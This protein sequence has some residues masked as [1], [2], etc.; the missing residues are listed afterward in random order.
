VHFKIRG[1]YAHTDADVER[2]GERDCRYATFLQSR[3]NHVPRAL[4]Q[5]FRGGFFHDGTVGAINVLR[6]WRRIE[7]LVTCPNIKRWND[8]R[9][10]YEFVNVDFRCRF[11]DVV[12]FR[13]QLDADLDADSQDLWDMGHAPCFLSAELETL[14]EEIAV[15]EAQLKEEFHSII[16][17]TDCPL[18][19]LMVFGSLSVDPTESAAF[20]IMQADPRFEIPLEPYP[21]TAADRVAAEEVGGDLTE[22]LRAVD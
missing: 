5:Y 15:F 9:T 2:N 1:G 7:L 11:E 21:P 19:L 16:I 22:P 4:W 8:A 6:D 3:A 18:G 10:A 12:H 17:D 20:A 13:L 14:T